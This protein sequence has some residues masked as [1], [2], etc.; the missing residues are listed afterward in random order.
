MRPPLRADAGKRSG[1]RL[2]YKREMEK[3]TAKRHSRPAKAAAFIIVFCVALAAVFYIL[4]RPVGGAEGKS[5][6]VDIPQGS[7]TDA[8]AKILKKKDLI[9]SETVFEIEARIT[10]SAKEFKAGSYLLSKSQSTRGIIRTIAEG[11]TAGYTV[12][13]DEGSAIYKLADQLE[14][15]GICKKKEFYKEVSD[16]KFDYDFITS[17]LPKGAERLEG[18]LYPDTYRVDL[19]AD[20]H[21]VIDAMLKRFNEQVYVPYAKKA[22]KKGSSLYSVLIKAS[23]IQKEAA[24]EDDMKKVSSVIDNRIKKD[25]P[26]Q[27]DS[28]LSYINKEDKILASISDTQVDSDYNP[29]KN[30]GLPPGPICSPSLTA[31]KAALYPADTD[32]MYFVASPKMDGTDVFS[33]TY[34]EFE[35]D[36]KAFEKAYRKYVKE[37][38]GAK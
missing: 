7:G 2:A 17:D 30:K 35:K 37:H 23:I 13:M 9:Q 5:I 34:K 28:I 27:M 32:Y 6:L 16:G 31:V 26:L 36:K 14:K 25:M 29:Y 11:K 22:E 3:K 18:L 15:D 8:I 38:P 19:D 33:E 24:G 21:D 4:S 10:G 12:T 20:A 1:I